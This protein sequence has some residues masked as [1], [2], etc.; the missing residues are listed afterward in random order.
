MGKITLALIAGAVAYFF[1]YMNTN[2]FFFAPWNFTW[3]VCHHM[4]YN[5]YNSLTYWENFLIDHIDWE[6]E[7]RT[8]FHMDKNGRYPVPEIDAKDGFSFE[9]LRELTNDFT[10]PAVVRGLFANTEAV[11]QWTPEFFMEIMAMIR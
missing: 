8:Y 9:K 6:L 2:D 3:T 4:E 11:E 10:T 1:A 7:S 5:C